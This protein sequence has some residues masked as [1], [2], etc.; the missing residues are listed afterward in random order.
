MTESSGLFLLLK[1]EVLKKRAEVCSFLSAVS[2]D[3]PVH[4]LFFICPLDVC[5][6]SLVSIVV[7]EIFV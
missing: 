1:R 7:Y 4:L 5:T 2:N 6:C 3:S